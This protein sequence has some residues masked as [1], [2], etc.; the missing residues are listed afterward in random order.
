MRSALQIHPEIYAC[1]LIVLRGLNNHQFSFQ[2]KKIR[3]TRAMIQFLDHPRWRSGILSP[4]QTVDYRKL[5]GSNTLWWQALYMEVLV[6]GWLV[7]E[8]TGSAWLVAIV[9]FCRSFPFLICG[10][11]SGLV[12]DRFGRRA[13]IIWM[14]GITF[15]AYAAIAIL[16]ITGRIAYW[17]LVV[18][19]L[20]LGTSWALD[21]PNRRALV[22][23]MVGKSKTVDAI[24]LESLGQGVART[25]GP[26]LV[27]WILAVFGSTGSFIT[28][29]AM[30][31]AAFGLLLALSNEPLTRTVMPD[32][33]PVLTQMRQGLSYVRHNQAIL[34]VAIT[35][36]LMNLFVFSYGNFL[37]IFAKDILQQGPVGMGVLG[38]ASG[39]GSFAGLYLVN[40]LRN[41]VGYGWIFMV[42]TFAE[43]VALAIF[44]FSGNYAFS[45]AMLAIVGFGQASF[46]IMQSS[47]VLMAAP[48]EMR[49][50]AMGAIVL[51]IGVGPLGKLQSGALVEWLGAPMGIG[52]QAIVAS[53]AM[54][55]VLILLPGIRRFGNGEPEAAQNRG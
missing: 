14:Q 17:H 32:R 8:L 16:L 7:L 29:A 48:D 34:A 12:A 39:V 23:D 24:L 15:A 4:L 20:V 33:T 52:L 6:V 35:T 25:L 49:G 38:A 26:F 28:L 21:W 54:V 53:V 31:L 1:P 43:C 46:G 42:G 50:R 36:A 11:L 30:S 13:T 55:L 40:L 51:A 2:S 37:P 19:A 22:P 41:R 3:E 27:G 9:G 18:S 47:I 45:F 44:A 5:L 10:N